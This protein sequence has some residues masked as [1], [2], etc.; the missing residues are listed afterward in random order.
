VHAVVVEEGLEL[1]AGVSLVGDEGLTGRG[2][3]A[4]RV[5]IPTDRGRRRVRRS[6]D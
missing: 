6:W 3:R 2:R 4:V 1:A 5:G